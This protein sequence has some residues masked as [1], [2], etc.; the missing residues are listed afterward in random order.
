MWRRWTTISTL[1]SSARTT[2]L[3]AAFAVIVALS[4]CTKAQQGSM[5]GAGVGALAGQ[6]I[7][8]DTKATL[9]GAGVGAMA[10]YVIGNEQDKAEYRQRRGDY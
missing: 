4:G 5:M 8:G 3:G 7:G 6:A 9:I 2:T 1:P 10:G